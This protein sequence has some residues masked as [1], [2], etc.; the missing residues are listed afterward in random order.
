MSQFSLTLRSFTAPTLPDQ[1]VNIQ[2]SDFKSPLS[3][4]SVAVATSPLIFT[5]SLPAARAKDSLYPATH[6]QLTY[7]FEGT[8]ES[9][10][11]NPI[12]SKDLIDSSTE[13]ESKLYTVQVSPEDVHR[14]KVAHGR[15]SDGE[16]S[17]YVWK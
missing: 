6:L 15:T 16:V 10:V 7:A 9:F 11:P 4:R 8:G 12:T 2:P 13:E 17:V 14:T 5:L 3:P 1:P